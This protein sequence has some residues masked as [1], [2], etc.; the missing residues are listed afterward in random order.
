M[1]KCR[2]AHGAPWFAVCHLCAEQVWNFDWPG[3]MDRWD[4]SKLITLAS[5]EVHRLNR[6]IDAQRHLL[7]MHRLGYRGVRIGG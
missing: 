2:C 1:T 3:G 6:E 7:N 5:I 4:G